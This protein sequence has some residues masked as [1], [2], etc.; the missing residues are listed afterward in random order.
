M[1]RNARLKRERR[2]KRKRLGIRRNR[3]RE[4]MPPCSYRSC[5]NGNPPGTHILQK[6]DGNFFSSCDDCI[7]PMMHALKGQGIDAQVVSVE[8]LEMLNRAATLDAVPVPD[9]PDWTGEKSQG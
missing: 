1:G 7:T 8:A 3:R 6:T 2:E 9:D 4:K 5:E